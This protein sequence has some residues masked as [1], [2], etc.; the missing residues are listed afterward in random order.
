MRRIVMD[1]QSYLFADSLARNLRAADSDFEVIRAR[2]PSET[3]GLCWNEPYALLMEVTAYTPWL[4]EERMKIRDEVKSRTPECK[5]V[6]LVDANTEQALA[7]QAKQAK[8]DGLI[9]QFIYGDS[10]ADYL[11]AQIDTL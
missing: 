11:V 2:T 10:S 8:K 9:D 6:L 7:E 5:I 1:M 3:A 4:F